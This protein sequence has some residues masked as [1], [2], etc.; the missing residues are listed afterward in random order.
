MRILTTIRIVI[1]TWVF[2]ALAMSVA[3]FI[4][5]G[6]VTEQNKTLDQVDDLIN[7]IFTLNILTNDYIIRREDRAK[8]Q[9]QAMHADIIQELQEI[10]FV[11]ADLEI[12]SLSSNANKIVN[13]FSQLVKNYE[14][15]VQTKVTADF[16]D[17]LIGQ[18]SSVSQDMASEAFII[19]AIAQDNISQIQTNFSRLNIVFLVLILL[20]AG[21][22]GVVM[23]RGVAVPVEALA[24]SEERQERLNELLTVVN[25]ILRHDVLRRLV[26]ARESLSLV[27][28]TKKTEE[29][30]KMAN[31]AIDEGV[32]VVNQMKELESLMNAETTLQKVAIGKTVES[33]VGTYPIKVSVSGKAKVMA[34]QVLRSV[35]D[36]LIRN[37]ILHGQATEVVVA[38]KKLANEI[39]VRVADNGS[40]IP[41]QYRKNIFEE[42]FTAGQSGNTGLGLYIVK[43]TIDRYG[44]SI[45]IEDNKP[46]GTIFVINF[47]KI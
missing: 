8:L 7:D 18:I 31:T 13:I 15:D 44:G 38:I 30:V 24:A 23:M 17:R 10:N 19:S 12:T 2:A 26:G 40:G 4:L 28:A 41:K 45:K 27:K 16:A 39:E 42:G 32:E 29:W 1:A 34:D 33:L 3:V 36:N 5:T 9:W 46:K 20:I 25:K 47:P 6:K 37:A 22:G 35:F 43:K 14:S 21:I 11:D